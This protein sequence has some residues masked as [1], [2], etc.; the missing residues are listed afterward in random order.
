[1]VDLFVVN[2]N[3]FGG[4]GFDL[5]NFFSCRELYIFSVVPRSARA[6]LVLLFRTNSTRA[7]IAFLG[8]E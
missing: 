3:V 4:F 7:Y 8:S 5:R 2:H 6:S 1:M